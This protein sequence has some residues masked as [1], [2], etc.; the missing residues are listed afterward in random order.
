MIDI[1]KAMLDPAAVFRSP[2]DVIQCIDLSREQQ[3]D[4][5]CC[6][7]YDARDMEIAADET[8][9]ASPS[10]CLDRILRALHTLST[11]QASKRVAAMKH[12]RRRAIRRPSR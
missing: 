12:G 10:S 6:W 4:I 9:L 7:A 11:Q 3:I 5:L 1:A 2:E 8:M